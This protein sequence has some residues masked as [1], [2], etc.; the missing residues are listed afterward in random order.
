MNAIKAFCGKLAGHRFFEFS[1]IGV[2]LVNAWFIAA[3]AVNPSDL[4]RTVNTVCLYIYTAEIFVRFFASDSVKAYFKDGWNLFDL[5]IVISGYI[6]ESL[7]ADGSVIAVLRTL[8]V[9]RIL[10]LFRTAYELR[11]IIR[12]LIM[13]LKTLAY[14]GLVMLIFQFVFAIAGI[15]LF[16]LPAYDTATAEQQAALAQLQEIAP[17]SPSVS[18]DPYGTV[19]ESMFTLLRMT[20][21]EDWTDLRYNLVAASRLKLIKVPPYVVT[22]YHVL[23]YC[24]SAFLLLNLIVS[25]VINN[26]DLIMSNER[27][28]HDP[29]K[30]AKQPDE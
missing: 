28:R 20:T 27:K 1:I 29:K 5:F 3:D 7:F 4:S 15:Y 23:W 16:K 22:A 9:F 21:G 24:F 30:P 18:P 14:N 17:N 13:S 10:K 19:P 25:A 26:Y 8:R 12:V 6:P 2:I 11:L